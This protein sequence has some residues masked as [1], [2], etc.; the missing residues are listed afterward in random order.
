MGFKTQA[1]FIYRMVVSLS[2]YYIPACSWATCNMA[3]TVIT[4][5][6]G[7]TKSPPNAFTKWFVFL[8]ILSISVLTDGTAATTTT[9][10]NITH[11]TFIFNTGQC[12]YHYKASALFWF[13]SPDPLTG[14]WG[15][16]TLLL[17]FLE[18]VNHTFKENLVVCMPFMM[19]TPTV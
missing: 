4:M 16:E 1:E 5:K 10:V 6:A 19:W 15:L 13:V 9:T 11:V 18:A 14:G 12:T 8:H 17:N 3:F 2:S 7:F